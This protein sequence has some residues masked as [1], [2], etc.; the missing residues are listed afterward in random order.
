MPRVPD[1]SMVTR[2]RKAAA[3]VNP[4]PTIK[5]RAF[6][7][8]TKD[9]YMSSQLRASDAGRGMF[10]G[11][12]TLS[13]PIACGWVNPRHQ[14]FITRPPPT[15]SQSPTFPV[16]TIWTAAGVDFS[17]EE[18][19]DYEFELTLPPGPDFDAIFDPSLPLPTNVQDIL[20]IAIDTTDSSELFGNTTISTTPEWPGAV[21]QVDEFGQYSRLNAQ[22]PTFPGVS[23][24]LQ[25]RN[26]PVIANIR[27]RFY[28]ISY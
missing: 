13:N 8:P 17:V 26:V 12:T 11:Q 2:M 9:G 7:A 10:P 22:N 24:I 1:A 27:I 4:D 20:R 18:T 16:V 3:T 5:S 19:V 28:G 15:G 6:V 25:F 14:G 21:L 23:T